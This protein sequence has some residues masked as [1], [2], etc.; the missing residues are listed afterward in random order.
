MASNGCVETWDI[1][2]FEESS[3][4]GMTKLDEGQFWANNSLKSFVSKGM[5]NIGLRLL[6][7]FR[8]PGLTGLKP[9]ASLVSM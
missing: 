6:F 4:E 5:T 7:E 1:M 8:P 2:R 9:G 3:M